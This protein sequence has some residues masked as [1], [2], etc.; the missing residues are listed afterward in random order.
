VSPPKNEG[1]GSATGAHDKPNTNQPKA[2]TSRTWQASFDAL[3]FWEKAARGKA[4]PV[5]L[6]NDEGW[7]AA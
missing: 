4:Q 1:P 3:G 5:R 6:L 2:S 7:W